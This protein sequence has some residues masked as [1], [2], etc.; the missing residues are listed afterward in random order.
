MARTSIPQ[1]KGVIEGGGCQS[2]AITAPGDGRDRFGVTRQPPDFA[3]R[4]AVQKYNGVRSLNAL[5]R[6]GNC[7]DAA[8]GAVC[9]P[10]AR[11]VEIAQLSIF[12]RSPK[13]EPVFVYIGDGDTI[14]LW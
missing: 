10:R 11:P 13:R 6:L 8:V 12:L 1:P 5:A 14:V 3:L 2:F 7:Q 4:L 9:K